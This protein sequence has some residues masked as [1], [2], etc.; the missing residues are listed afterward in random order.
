MRAC[1]CKLAKNG[2]LYFVVVFHFHAHRAEMWRTV[3]RGVGSVCGDGGFDCCRWWNSTT[4]AV[5]LFLLRR[6][7][8]LE[9]PSDVA[10]S[11]YNKK[12]NRI[13]CIVW[14]LKFNVEA[15]AVEGSS[16]PVSRLSSPLWP[17]SLSLFLSWLCMD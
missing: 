4:S 16:Q 17:L 2:R 13:F 11:S 12:W 15:E 7:R 8:T 5:S 6:V 1:V 10:A 3:W 9:G 14:C